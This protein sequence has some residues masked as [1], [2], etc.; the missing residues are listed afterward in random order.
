MSGVTKLSV[1]QYMQYLLDHDEGVLK[2]GSHKSDE[3]AFCALEL[4]NA[5]RGYDWSDQPKGLPDLRSLNDA[6][7]SSDIVRTKHLLP[8]MSA[9]SDWSLWSDNRKQKWASRVA[10]SVTRDVLAFANLV[11]PQPSSTPR[12]A[13]SAAWSAAL[14]AEAARSAVWSAASA[15]SAAWSAAWSAASAA[16]AAESA[17]SAARSAA[18][19]AWSADS[20]LIKACEIFIR[21]AEETEAL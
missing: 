1:E 12:S 14:A 7:W 17:A 3:R 18:E 9:L 10:L 16:L 5:I 13:P 8:V 20:A 15:S 6:R 19:A 2:T 4:D 21:H 11:S